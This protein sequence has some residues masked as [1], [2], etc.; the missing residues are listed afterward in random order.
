MPAMPIA[1]N[2]APIVVGIK[3]DEERDQHDDRHRTAGIGRKARNADGGEDEDERHAGEQDIERDLVGCLLPHRAFDQ[4]N[5]AVEEG[6]TRALAVMR[7]L[8]PVRRNTV[9]RR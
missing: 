7:T 1:D 9:C 6:S 8:M 5:H 2:S 3:A 4:R